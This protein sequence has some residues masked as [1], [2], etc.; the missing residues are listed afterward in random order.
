MPDFDKL[1]KAIHEKGRLAIMTLLATRVSWPFQDIKTELGMSDGNLITHL[2]TLHKLGLD[3]VD[4]RRA[5]EAG[6]ELVHGVVVE[7]LGRVH[8]LE[9]ALL[10]HGDAVAHRHRLHLVVRDVDRRRADLALD[11]RDL[12]AHLHAQLRVQVG[13]RLVHQEGLRLAHDRAAQGN[14]LALPARK[15]PR[16]PLQQTFDAE[17]AGGILDIAMAGTSATLLDRKWESA[18]LVNVDNDTLRRIMDNPDAMAAVER[19]EDGRREDL[20]G[21]FPDH[22]FARPI[23][24]HLELLILLARHNGCLRRRSAESCTA[25]TRVR[26]VFRG[27]CRA[28]D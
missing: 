26:P 24:D 17:D 6:D 2:R 18:L 5:D 15:L 13:E 8:L 14:A 19:I 12:G 28:P 4:R 7:H 27:T 3:H 11:A 1:D 22:V 21:P 23:E 10:H 9:V 25:Q 20:F 16:L